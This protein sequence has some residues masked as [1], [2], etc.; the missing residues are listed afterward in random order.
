MT[1]NPN[2]ILQNN[3]RFLPLLSVI[4][5]IGKRVHIPKGEII[6]DEGTPCDFFF[7]VE[8]GAFRAYRHVREIEVTLGFSFSGDIDTCPYAYFNHIHSLDTITALIDST[9]IRVERCDMDSVIASN[10]SMNT[11]VET[12]L[13]HYLETVIQR[14]IELKSCTAEE[15]YVKLLR[16]Q[17]AIIP[18]IPLKYMASYLGITQERLSRIRKKFKN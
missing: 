4:Y 17:P 15:N 18:L 10:P 13:T 9:I 7:L 3:S 1:V 16:T 5:S 14:N 6:I 12:L 8:Q 2:N 11:F